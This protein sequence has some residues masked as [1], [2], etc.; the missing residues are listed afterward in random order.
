[1]HACYLDS[2][3]CKGGSY[4]DYTGGSHEREFIANVV[5]APLQ[6]R[7]FDVIYFHFYIKVFSDIGKT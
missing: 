6:K 5:V 7:Y 1:M 3:V 4:K 2:L